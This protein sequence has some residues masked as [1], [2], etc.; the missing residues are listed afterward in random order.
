MYIGQ[1][2]RAL[3][4]RT[5]EHRS[6]FTRG[7]P[8]KS[9]IAQH[10]LSSGHDFDDFSFNVVQSAVKRRILDRLEEPNENIVINDATIESKNEENGRFLWTLKGHNTQVLKEI[11]ILLSQRSLRMLKKR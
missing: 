1:T 6:A 2:G 11:L 8:E 4:T 3:K 9:A 7:L 10:C 5:A